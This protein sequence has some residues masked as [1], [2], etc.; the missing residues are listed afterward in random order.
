MAL[1]KIRSGSINLADNFA[2]TGNITGI[3]AGIEWQT[4]VTIPTNA[5]TL[6]LSGIPSTAKNVSVLWFGM[7][8]SSNAWTAFKVGTSGG[9]KSS[10]YTG[11]AVYANGNQFYANP[12]ESPAK[13]YQTLTYYAGRYNGRLDL[14]KVFDNNWEYNWQFT[15]ETN[16]TALNNMGSGAVTSLDA[17]LSQINFFR[18]NNFNNAGKM[19]LG[20][21]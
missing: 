19:V 4:P 9:L 11:G 16:G 20:Y 21:F 14:A 1:S 17:A 13:T 15:N 5:A 7:G 18:T 12:P 3:P 10:G 8:Q 2:F 6:T